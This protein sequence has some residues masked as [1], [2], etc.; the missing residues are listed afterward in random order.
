MSDQFIVIMAG[1]RGERF[2]PE[3]RLHRPKHLLP[4]VG[5]KPMLRQTLDRIGDLVPS[6]NIFIITNVTQQEAIREM[7]PELAAEQVVAEPVGRDTA[8][9]VGLAMLL[10]KRR[11]P[12]GVFALLPA[13]H[14]IHDSEGFQACLARGFSVARRRDCLVTIGITPTQP[15]TGYGYIQRGAPLAELEGAK[16][17]HVQRFVEKPDLAT[18]TAYLESGEYYWN[19]GMFVWKVGV[20]ERAFSKYQ[21]SILDGIRVIEAALD[22]GK[23]LAQALAETY[24]QLTRI[25]IDFAIMEKSDQ[26]VTIES[27]FDWDDVGEW[28]AIERHG[29]KDDAGNLL[30]G[31]SALTDSTGNIIYNDGKRVTALLGVADLIVVHTADAT[32][33][34]HRDKAQ[35][36][37]QIVAQ[38]MASDQTTSF[39]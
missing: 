11:N 24:G 12:N 27:S 14:V 5:D 30:A 19:A 39:V 32:L 31:L 13:D 9:A 29:R 18:A 36:I 22:G 38:L 21:P 4:I 34:C 37:K 25:S 8:P 20:I 26:V 28:T 3:S 15:A 17:F 23:D 35:Q 7:C 10:V 33:V 2:W 1:G 16:G 6:S